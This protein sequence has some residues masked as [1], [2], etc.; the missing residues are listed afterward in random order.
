[1]TSERT[2]PATPP[3]S[4]DG[5]IPLIGLEITERGDGRSSARLTVGPQHMNPHGVIH[6]AVPYALA[7]TG[8]GAAAYTVMNE[9][10]MCATIEV[11]IVYLAPVREGI[12]ECETRVVQKG[13]TVAVLESEVRNGDRLVAKALG[14]YSIFPRKS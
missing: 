8:M 6:G 10:E 11:K 2:Q 13:R 14:T 1:M 9:G 5:F 3:D 12:L 4:T 7:D